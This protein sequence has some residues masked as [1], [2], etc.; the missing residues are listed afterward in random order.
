M[1]SC[2]F[3]IKSLSMTKL[4]QTKEPVNNSFVSS[5]CFFNKWYCVLPEDGTHI[6]KNVEA[7]LM[8]VLIKNV[9]LVGILNGVC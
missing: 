2:T 8:S 6:L 4:L 9:H 7:H 5:I 1:Y 3:Y